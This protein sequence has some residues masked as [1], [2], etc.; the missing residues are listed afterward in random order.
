[1]PD[2]GVDW[3]DLEAKDAAEAP[4]SASEAD[5]GPT[6]S[7]DADNSEVRYAVVV[8]GRNRSATPRTF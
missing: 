2:L 3:P 5:Q 7:P 1:M 4:P 8:E 6:P